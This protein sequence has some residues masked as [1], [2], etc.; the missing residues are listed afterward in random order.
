MSG[1]GGSPHTQVLERLHL[2]CADPDIP[3]GVSKEACSYVLED[4]SARIAQ[5]ASADRSPRP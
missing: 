3:E 5:E 4:Y 1:V 2:G